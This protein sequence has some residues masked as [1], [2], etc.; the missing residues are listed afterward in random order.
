MMPM[1]GVPLRWSLGRVKLAR[2]ARLVLLDEM[3]R[4]L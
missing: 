2:L 4:A 3:F 1:T